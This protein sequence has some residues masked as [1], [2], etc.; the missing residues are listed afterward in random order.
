M[1]QEAAY[2]RQ[3][4]EAGEASPPTE[5]GRT[6]RGRTLVLLRLTLLIATAYL[7]LAETGFKGLSNILLA[8][9][10]VG[11]ASN[12]VVM[13][14]PRRI[15]STTTFHGVIIGC[16]TV[17]ITAALIL[18]GKF[19]AEFFYL[20]FFVLFLAAVGENLFLIATGALIVGVAYILL[21]A[22]SSSLGRG[23]VTAAQEAARAARRT[24]A[25][26]AGAA[27]P[28]PAPAR[29]AADARR[30]VRTT[31]PRPPACRRSRRPRAAS[32]R[33]PRSARA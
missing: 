28:A 17:W 29:R 6:M 8:I 23:D 15:T 22:V 10:L 14:I 33:R 32:L 19:S 24:G 5:A 26:R 9:L 11:F 2:P 31:R 12:I 30:A 16:D 20:Y 3:L 4:T 21:G 27:A 25:A 7:L 18:S 1:T 13:W